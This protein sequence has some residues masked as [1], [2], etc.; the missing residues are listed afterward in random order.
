M[1]VRRAAL[2]AACTA[3]LYPVAG[4]AR[5]GEVP[6]SALRQQVAAERHAIRLIARPDI[7]RALGTIA[8]DWHARTSGLLPETYARLHDAIREVAFMAALQIIDND[9]RR[10]H[11]I[12]ISAAPHRW[13]GTSVPGGRWG[14]NNPDTLYFTIPVEPGS[15]YVITGHRNGG[16]LTDANFTA[17]TGADWG[18]VDNLAG[19]DLKI[20][21]DGTYRITVDDQPAAEGGNHLRISG[22]ANVVLIRNTLADWAHEQ[23][24]TLTVERVDG[25]PA[26][27]PPTEQDLASAIVS[28]LKAVID[29]SVNGLQPA[30]LRQPANVIPQPGAIADKPGFLVT[31]RNALA[32]FRLADDE[33]LIATFNPG[34][35]GYA[36]L[37]VTSIWG[38]TPDA[39]AH[40]ISLNTRQAVPN[41]DGTITVV[42]AQRDPG[43][44]NWIDLAGLHEGIIMLR[45]Q[46]L[47]AALSGAEGPAVTSQ[48]V[49]RNALWF[50]LP[51]STARVT[52]KERRAQLQRR[53]AG[54]DR[55]FTT[56]ERLGA[57]D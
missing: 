38:I 53:A 10:P 37:P 28:R 16:G 19:R 21:A 45:W 4:L 33:V 57:G 55:R 39:R 49:K 54:F 2:L 32:H 42:L 44:A 31:Q 52:P 35:A 46:L 22:A 56:R 34:G 43:V 41:P 11:V 23:P 8:E 1:F 15:R 26:G 51:A 5:A 29:H 6:P 18:A 7:Q 27:P 14:I 3:A 30:I 20:D 9:P 47:A 50:A 12:E 17:Q 13:Y 48:V 24:D 40:Q 36:T 25:P